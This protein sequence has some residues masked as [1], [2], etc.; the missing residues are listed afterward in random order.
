MPCHIEGLKANRVHGKHPLF[1]D[2]IWRVV[3]MCFSDMEAIHLDT[4]YGCHQIGWIMRERITEIP[5]KHSWV[6]AVTM[7]SIGMLI[8]LM[9]YK[10]PCPEIEDLIQ[11]SVD[12]NH[13][14]TIYFFLD[15]MNVFYD[16]HGDSIKEKGCPCLDKACTKGYVDMVKIITGIYLKSH[17][18]KLLKHPIPTITAVMSKGFLEI[19]KLLVPHITDIT[20]TQGLKS[21]ALYNHEEVFEYALKHLN[22]GF[23]PCIPDSVL[24]TASGKGRLNILK[25]CLD[26]SNSFIPLEAFNAAFVCGQIEV[27]QFILSTHPTY[28]PSE[29]VLIE[30]CKNGCNHIISSLPGNIPIPSECL[31]VSAK[32]KNSTLIYTLKKRL[33]TI[34][35]KKSMLYDAIKSGVSEVVIAVFECGNFK[36]INSSMKILLVTKNCVKALEF[37]HGIEI[38][39]Y[40]DETLLESARL[41]NVS[42]IE[43]IFKSGLVPSEETIDES[44][45]RLYVSDASNDDRGRAFSLI[46]NKKLLQC[47]KKRSH[48]KPSSSDDFTTFKRSKYVHQ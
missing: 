31:S 43:D 18:N 32:S 25:M 20:M 45:R 44:L 23:I 17:R 40:T 37:F 6:S 46:N 14:Q 12:R 24:I 4:V 19:L 15:P 38:S 39:V 1:I 16:G 28:M 10:V 30:T 47:P 3:L 36:S 13:L 9:K 35:F 34:V 11:F 8:Y 42:I 41:C 2:S 21:A 26:H 33:P 27:V 7:K 5:S 48:Q 29:E 22:P